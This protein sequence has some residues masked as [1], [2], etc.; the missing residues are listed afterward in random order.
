MLSPPLRVHDACWSKSGSFVTSS[1]PSPAA[2]IF[3][4]MSSGREADGPDA[5]LEGVLLEGV[6][7]E[8]H[9]DPSSATTRHAPANLEW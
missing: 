8:L 3:A 5:A 6:P 7:L 2:L 1:Q 4:A 9:A